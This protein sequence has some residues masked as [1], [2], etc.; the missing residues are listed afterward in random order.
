MTG[1]GIAFELIEGADGLNRLQREWEELEAC[2]ASHVFQTYAYAQLWMRTVG[3]PGGAKPM[4]VV[5]REEDTVVGIL[6]ACRVRDNGLPL[7]AWLGGPR[8]LDYGDVLF[9]TAS[10]VTTVDHFVGEALTMLSRGARGAMLLLTNVRDDATAIEPLRARLRT[11]KQ[12][13]APY[14]PIE[15][16]YDDYLASRSRSL[17]YN[18]NRK[19]RRLS[20]EGDAGMELLEP[21]DPEVLPTMERLVEFVRARHNTTGNR[22]N[23]FDESY[24]RLRTGLAASPVG[25]VSRIVVEGTTIAACL[26]AVHRNRL[27]CLVHGYDDSYATYSPGQLLHGFIIRSCFERGWDPCDL[28]W[29]DEP[30]K[31]EW[32]DLEE[33]LTSFASDD[34]KGALYSAAITTGRRLAGATGSRREQ[35][36]KTPD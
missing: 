33:P 36:P 11:V 10:A 30:Y 14:V 7:I 1:G 28:C 2:S 19:W 15:G 34:A 24:V 25:R 12:T 26:H 4:I 16:T 21:G 13:T 23:L 29:G 17:R 3:V 6:P 8:A 27:Y 20:R 31:Y 5:G 18:L 9:D 35:P 32:T 22:T